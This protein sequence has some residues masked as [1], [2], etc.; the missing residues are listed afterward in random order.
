MGINKKKLR[1]K[2]DFKLFSCLLSFLSSPSHHHRGLPHGSF[3]L[4]HHQRGPGRKCSLVMMIFLL[5]LFPNSDFYVYP[6]FIG[7]SLLSMYVPAFSICLCFQ[8]PYF[9]GMALLSPYVTASSV[10][11]CFLRLSLLPTYVLV[12]S[13]YICFLC[14]SL[15]PISVLAS[16]ICPPFLH[17]SLFSASVPVSRSAPVSTSAPAPSSIS[18]IDSTWQPGKTKQT[19]CVQ[20]NL[21]VLSR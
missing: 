12:S 18:Y 1:K 3:H 7:L 15:F 14:L 9:L 16:Y 4:S 21:K 8:S 5:L 19:V 17:Q 20:S 2:V 10:Y 11:L 13:V 6:Y